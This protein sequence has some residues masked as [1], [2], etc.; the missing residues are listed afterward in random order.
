[1][2]YTVE[3]ITK[4]EI[5]PFKVMVTIVSEKHTPCSFQTTEQ[6]AIA[7]HEKYKQKRFEFQEFIS[8]LEK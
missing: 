3:N 1:M 2:E 8:E 4:D 6:K 5:D 7:I